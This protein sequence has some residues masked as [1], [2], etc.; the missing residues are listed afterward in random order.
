MITD[1]SDIEA[2]KETFPSNSEE[3]IAQAL[4][5]TS[6]RNEAAEKLLAAESSSEPIDGI[7]RY[8]I[9]TQR[10]GGE[11]RYH[12]TCGNQNIEGLTFVCMV[13]E[14]CPYSSIDGIGDF[15][16]WAGSEM[17]K[18]SRKCMKLSCNFHRG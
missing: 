15:L 17:P 9:Q 1:T 5:N 3:E 14:K 13:P 16:E 7:C 11:L 18:T 4:E 10:K 8:V 12:L 6:S 2:L